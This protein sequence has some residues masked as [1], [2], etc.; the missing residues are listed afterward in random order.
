MYDEELKEV[1]S[2]WSFEETI[3]R[4]QGAIARAGLKLFCE[5]D[6]QAGAL[7]LG[8]EMLPATVLFYGHPRAGTPI[9]LA[10]PL[11]A[12]DLPLR[13]LIRVRHDGKV[14]IA[15][16]PIATVLRRAAVPEPFVRGLNPAQEILVKAVCYE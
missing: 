6:H 8:L 15:F 2:T 4:L 5:I 11:T 9:M 3:R 7:E 13:V 10:A 16:H 12:L 1:L 14:V